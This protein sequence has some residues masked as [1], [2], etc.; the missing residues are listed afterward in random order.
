[1]KQILLQLS[2]S[3]LNYTQFMEHYSHP[4]SGPYY[5]NIR[6]N[7]EDAED[8]LKEIS[9][10]LQWLQRTGIGEQYGRTGF[11]IRENA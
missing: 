2:K 4:E 8:P 5:V 6:D 3:E 7:Y 9:L 11:T 10:F 1:M